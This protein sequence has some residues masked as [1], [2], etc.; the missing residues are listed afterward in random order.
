MGTL[1]KRD[2]ASRAQLEQADSG[3]EAA[4]ARVQAAQADLGAAE[5]ATADSRVA[6]RFAGVIGRRFVSRGEF[7]QPG[8]KL[9]EL[10]S[11][12]PVEVEFSLPESDAAGSRSGLPLDVAVA[13]YPG[14]VFHAD[15]LDGLAGRRRAHPHPAREGAARQIPTAACARVCSR[16]RTSA[17]PE[18]AGVLLVPEEAR[19]AA[20]RRR[21]GVPHAAPTARAPSGGWCSS[22]GS[23][24]ARS[25][26]APAS[27]PGDT[28]VV[29]GHSALVDGARR[30]QSDGSRERRR[31]TAQVS[32]SDLCIQRPVLTLMLTLSL[33]VFGVLGYFELG[34]DQMPNMEFPVVTV[35]AQLE[36][37]S[38]ETMEEDVTEVLEEHLNTIGGPALAEVHHDAGRDDDHR[39]VRARARH[40]RGRAG[41]A[42]QG[43]GAPAYDLPRESR[44]R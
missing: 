30:A 5:R 38:P 15:R 36:G 21:G 11:L 23:R 16:A 42:R 9:F 4:R 25:R 19:A 39:R 10:V 43:R 41:R 14:E 13:P 12:D 40:R 2:V 7:V 22:A 27:P 37:A 6:A 31:A 20:R 44:R 33:V 35:T 32:L 1:A 18:R 28:V 24:A 26:S 17:S 29:R 3:L 8:Q 34:V